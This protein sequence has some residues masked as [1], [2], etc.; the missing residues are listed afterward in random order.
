MALFIFAQIAYTGTSEITSKS[1]DKHIAKI[2]KI[3]A[4]I[5]KILPLLHNNNEL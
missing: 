3:L 1:N 5:R 2:R 4:R